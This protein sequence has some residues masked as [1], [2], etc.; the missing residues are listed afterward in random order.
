VGGRYRPFSVIRPTKPA[1]RFA[2]FAVIAPAP[3]NWRYRPEADARF[4]SSEPVVRQVDRPRPDRQAL[5]SDALLLCMRLQYSWTLPAPDGRRSASFVLYL[6][7]ETDDFTL[8][9]CFSG[10]GAYATGRFMFDTNGNLWSGMN[11]MP[12][13]QSGVNKSTGGGVGK[14][15]PTERRFP[16]NHRLHRHGH[17]RRGLGLVGTRLSARRCV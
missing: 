16:A 9:L 17:Q 2:A 15:S 10:G 12:G 1:V 7:Y 8:S 3:G 11:W 13:S 5:P 6:V 4:D 14:Y